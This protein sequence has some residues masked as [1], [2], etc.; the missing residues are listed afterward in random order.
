MNREK[1][2]H[3][4]SDIR[5]DVDFA[6][7]SDLIE[8]GLIDSFD[9]VALVGDINNEFGIEI[10][11]MDITPENFNTVDGILALIERLQG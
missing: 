11:I 7:E 2:L 6:A 5:E 10:G 3:I 1:L 9:M 4:L 8:N